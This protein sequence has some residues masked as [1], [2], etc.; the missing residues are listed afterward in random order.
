MHIYLGH[1][2]E[3]LLHTYMP[4][5]RLQFRSRWSYDNVQVEISWNNQLGIYKTDLLAAYSKIDPRV[6]PF[7]LFVKHWSKVRKLRDTRNGGLGSYAWCLMCIYF[8]MKVAKPPVVP[9]L[10]SQAITGYSKGCDVSF[11]TNIAFS[12][13]NTMVRL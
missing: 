7:V 10:Q 8:L 12:K 13:D 11:T 9:N 5:I 6:C 1:S 3:L 2:T 4:L